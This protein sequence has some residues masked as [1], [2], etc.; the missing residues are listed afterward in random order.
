MPES[1]TI[2]ED[3]ARLLI[4]YRQT[5]KMGHAHGEWDIKEHGMVKLWITEKIDLDQKSGEKQ[6]VEVQSNV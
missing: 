3:E 1:L 4:K 2:S 5:K 6:L